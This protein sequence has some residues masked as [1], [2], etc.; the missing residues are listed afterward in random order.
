MDLRTSCTGNTSQ[1]LATSAAKQTF[2]YCVPDVTDNNSS[3]ILDKAFA[4]LQANNNFNDM[5]GSVVVAWPIMLVGTIL[6][7]VVG[8]AFIQLLSCF[9]SVVV[10]SSIILINL[11]FLLCA[12]ML[13]QSANSYKENFP[14]TYQDMD[15]YRVPYY[16]AIVMIVVTVISLLMTLVLI[17][18]VRL[19]IKVMNMTGKAIA[20]ARMIMF[21]P[22]I[23]TGLLLIV[24]AVWSIVSVYIF[25]NGKVTAVQSETLPGGVAR[26]VEFS[27]T[28][29]YV[30]LYHLFGLFWIGGFLNA[31]VQMIVGFVGISWYFA[32]Q[33]EGSRKVRPHLTFA[34]SK[35]VLWYHLGTAAFGSF[36]IAVV[37]TIRAIFEYYVRQ[38]KRYQNNLVIKMTICCVRCCLWCVECCLRFINKMA[39]IF[40]GL[41]GKSF[42]PAACEGIVYVGSN[43]LRVGVLF[44]LKQV[45]LTLGKLLT[46]AVPAGIVFV[47]LS[48]GEYAD[49]T[50]EMAVAN[51]FVPALIV[52]FFG[53]MVGGTF[54]SVYDTMSDAVLMSFCYNEA[55][56][57]FVE[58]E[59]D[60]GAQIKSISNEMDEQEAAKGGSA[61]SGKAAAASASGPAVAP[62]TAA[63]VPDE[64]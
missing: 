26:T 23:V 2:G 46:A 30:F 11:G 3:S 51:P 45:F 58:G 9:A 13:F 15:D 48:S 60:P 22:V 50:S 1:I 5:I 14:D 16:G 42:L 32:P 44:V 43:F 64:K 61:P 35:V 12:L 62:E 17:P 21:V 56:K 19:A 37:Q 47:I 55:K 10:Y 7:L 34:M 24:Y 28:Q 29:R 54:A 31:V 53:Y 18:R 52:L 36:I 59:N 49:P 20:A 8:F 4:K 57:V 40:V 63:T 27:D 6:A 38:S 39:Y 41:T 25:S 33:V